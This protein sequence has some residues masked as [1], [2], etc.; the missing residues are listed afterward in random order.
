MLDKKKYLIL[1]RY[2]GS[3]KDL[4]TDMS[5][6]DIAVRREFTL[7]GSGFEDQNLEITMFKFYYIFR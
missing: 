2:L 3:F 6:G 5:K 1:K 4:L 7:F